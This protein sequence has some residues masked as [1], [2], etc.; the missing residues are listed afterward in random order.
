MDAQ[1][2]RGNIHPN[3]KGRRTEANDAD[4]STSAASRLASIAADTR[5]DT[6]LVAAFL[7][8]ADQHAFA[9]VVRRHGPAVL[10]VCRRFLGPT[11][12]AEDA[13]QATF[14][15]SSAAHGDG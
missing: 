6:H 1:S 3:G 2:G 7:S 14:S 5:S 12:D 10:G 13:F 8:D 9:G 11:P 4:Q 15:S